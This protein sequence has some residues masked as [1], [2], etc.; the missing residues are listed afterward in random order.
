MYVY[1]P[2]PTLGGLTFHDH[3]FDAD[4]RGTTLQVETLFGEAPST[5]TWGRNQG[6]WHD[7]SALTP[8]TPRTVKNILG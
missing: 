2:P 4:N 8:W 1:E 3:H 5:K 6:I 7:E